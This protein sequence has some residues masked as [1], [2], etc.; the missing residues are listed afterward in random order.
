MLTACG[1]PCGRET[2][3]KPENGRPSRRKNKRRLI[4]SGSIASKWKHGNARVEQG[5]LHLALEN[6][7]R[8]LVELTVPA[9]PGFGQRKGDEEEGRRHGNMV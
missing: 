5:G 7:A 1:Y 3:E 6:G 2:E 4:P 8:W 9:V